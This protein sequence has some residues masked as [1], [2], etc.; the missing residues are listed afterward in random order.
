MQKRSD[1]NSHWRELVLELD[2]RVLEKAL[3]VRLGVEPTIQ[4]YFDVF[5]E[6][7]RDL[8]ADLRKGLQNGKVVIGAQGGFDHQA[9]V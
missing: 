7:I 9:I 8:V 1:K 4:A 5:E 6:Q 3:D 2:F